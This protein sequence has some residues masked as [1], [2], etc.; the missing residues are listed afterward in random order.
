MMMDMDFANTIHIKALGATPFSVMSDCY[1]FGMMSGCKPECP[2]FIRGGCE[3]QDE[4]ERLF[5]TATPP[6]GGDK[7]REDE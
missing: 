1:R 2:V 5:Q 3:L 6:Q 7:E 4:N